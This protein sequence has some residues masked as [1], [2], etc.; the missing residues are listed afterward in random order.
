[1]ERL[2]RLMSG[3]FTFTAGNTLTAAQLN[4]N[5]MAGLPYNYQVG[6]TSVTLTSS[7]TWSYGSTN[8]T[9]L[10]GFTVDPY[11]VGNVETTATTSANVCHFDATGPTTMTV[12]AL[13]SGAS[14]ATLAVRW[15]A[16]QATSSTAAGS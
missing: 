9:G 10:T 8:V 4:T 2:Y 5:I 16:I 3:R 7:A 11:V 12:Y 15:I 14:T 13:R 6:T 1:M